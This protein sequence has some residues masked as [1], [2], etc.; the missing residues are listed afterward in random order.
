MRSRRGLDGSDDIAHSVFEK[1]RVGGTIKRER[2]ALRLPIERQVNI[3]TGCYP[4]E[5]PLP[6]LRQ[7]LPDP[8][9][10]EL[11]KVIATGITSPVLAL[12]F[13]MR[14]VT[15]KA[16]LNRITSPVLAL[17]FHMRGV[18]PKAR[19]NNVLKCCEELKPDC[20]AALVMSKSGWLSISRAAS[21]RIET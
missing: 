7:G 16:R 4:L 21:S 20:I 3:E 12:V 8:G 6:L 1:A 10:G 9:L 13:Q 18:T 14:G 19:L 5:V 11:G 15:P 2:G 17:D